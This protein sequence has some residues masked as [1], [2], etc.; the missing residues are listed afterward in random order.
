MKKY[1]I[2]ERY[3]DKCMEIITEHCFSNPQQAFFGEE[4]QKFCSD[5]KNIYALHYLASM[6][7]LR[8]VLTDES[9][10]PTV[11]YLEKKGILHS[12]VRREKRYSAIKGFI[13]GVVA[14]IFTGL[15]LPILANTATTLLTQ[16]LLQ[17]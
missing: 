14:T 6:D 17:Q 4:L 11:V 5:S 3:L 13:V 7:E 10:I 15:I 12:Y 2:T 1:K 8:L 9:T 16:W